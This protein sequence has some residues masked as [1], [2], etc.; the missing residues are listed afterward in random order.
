MFGNAVND[1]NHIFLFKAV[2]LKRKTPKS[3]Q[4][5]IFKL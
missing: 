2:D 4:I 3:R 5:M 1:E